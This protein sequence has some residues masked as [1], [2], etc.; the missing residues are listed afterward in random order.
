MQGV[1]RLQQAVELLELEMFRCHVQMLK[2][3]NLEWT[4]PETFLG[5]FTTLLSKEI[6]FFR[7]RPIAFLL[8]DF[9]T[10]R[11]PEPVQIVLNRIIWERRATHIFKLSSEKHGAWLYD[12]HDATADISREMVEIDWSRIFSLR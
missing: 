3:L 10:H 1:S 2:G 8:D 7:E 6:T 5:D 12:S 9:S 11:L 4:T